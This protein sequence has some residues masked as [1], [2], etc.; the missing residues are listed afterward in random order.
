M[1]RLPAGG[2]RTGSSSSAP[3]VAAGPGSSTRLSAALT[4]RVA[5]SPPLSSNGAPA[6]NGRAGFVPG[7]PVL[8]VPGWADTT[9]ARATAMGLAP[10]QPISTRL[11]IFAGTSNPVRGGQ[12]WG[13]RFFWG[14]QAGCMRAT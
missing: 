4:D 14:V 12:G 6:A 7:R 13:V 8:D 9:L 10:Q 5:S 1:A 11:R 3:A 2:R